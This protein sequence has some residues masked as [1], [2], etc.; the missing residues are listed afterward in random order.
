MQRA[1]STETGTSAG[2]FASI[3]HYG[4]DTR[5]ARFLLSLKHHYHNMLN[6]GTSG[7]RISGLGNGFTIVLNVWARF[8][9]AH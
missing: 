1:R 5:E 8:L 9:T 7:D 6:S 4:Y 3:R 2:S